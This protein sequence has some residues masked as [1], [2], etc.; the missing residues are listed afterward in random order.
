MKTL[1]HKSRAVGQS[2]NSTL[3]DAH[4]RAFSVATNCPTPIIQAVHGLI[5]AMA[6]A[7][8]PLSSAINAKEL[9]R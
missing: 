6:L 4:T 2:W 8:V 1:I 3:A 9:T 5:Q 7:G